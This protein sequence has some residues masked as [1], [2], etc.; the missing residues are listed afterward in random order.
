MEKQIEIGFE[1]RGFPWPVI[2]TVDHRAARGG[3]VHGRRYYTATTWERALVYVEAILLRGNA[4][5]TKNVA[6]TFTITELV[7]Q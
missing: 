3:V 2:G 6:G 4:A 1:K 7:M 5:R